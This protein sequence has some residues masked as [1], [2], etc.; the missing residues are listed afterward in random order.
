M[1]KVEKIWD[2][3]RK[4]WLPGVGWNVNEEGYCTCGYCHRQREKEK[5]ET[6]GMQVPDELFEIK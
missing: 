5:K 3:T 1:K 6:Q 4:L 2:E